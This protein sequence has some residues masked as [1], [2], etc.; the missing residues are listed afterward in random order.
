MKKNPAPRPLAIRRALV[1]DSTG[2]RREHLT[3]VLQG[4]RIA[5][6]GPDTRVKIPKGA[7]VIEGNGKA[8]LPGLI[9][10]H[11]HYCLDASPDAIRSLQQDD[12]TVTAIKAATHAQ[13][14]LDGGITTVRDVGSRDHISI[15]VSRAIRAG[16]IPGPRTLNAGLAVCMTGGHA[17]F[18][19]R[20]ADGPD[21]V[22]KAVREQIRA[23]ADVI[24]FIATGGVLT[25]GVSPGA[26]QLTP[27]ELRAG[28]EEAT[29]AGRRVAA[30]AHGAEGMKNAIRAGVHSIEHGTLLDD[31]AID[32]FLTHGTFLVP[33]LSAIQSGC[34]MG[35][36]HGMPDDA[37]RKCAVLG[38]EQKKTFRKAM[39]AGVRIAMGTDAGTPFNPHGRNAQELRRMV[40]FGMTPMQ[41]IEAATHSAATLLGLEHEIGTIET[42]KEADLLLVNGNPLDDIALLEEP[43][44]VEWVIQGGKI[45]KGATG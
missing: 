32:L 25:P 38:E 39:K 16:I 5:T 12:P 26:A 27:E 18:I 3:V 33:T 10:C 11:I 7:K 21:E 9:D 45:V 17:W 20:Q 44:N 23:G 1:I 14:T 35:R 6:V 19:G 2:T 13:A 43:T 34:E 4:S 8:L 30:H 41:A 28:V 15:S 24:K 42:G 29:R 40:A 37:V 36:A 31:E 22:I